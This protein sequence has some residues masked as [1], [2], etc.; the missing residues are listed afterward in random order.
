LISL[1]QLA[2]RCS[3]VPGRDPSVSTTTRHPS[4]KRRRYAPRRRFACPRSGPLRG[5][6]CVPRSFYLRC[7]IGRSAPSARSAR[8]NTDTCTNGCGVWLPVWLLNRPAG[9][10]LHVRFEDLQCPRLAKVAA[11]SVQI[12]KVPEIE[13][14]WIAAGRLPCSHERRD[15][16]YDL[17]CSDRGHRL[18]GLWRDLVE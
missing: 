18:P 16:E 3:L 17:G 15:K 11:G 13:K 8:I 10:C 14:R 1:R 5:G 9:L 2:F 6:R 4:N 7:V 12:G